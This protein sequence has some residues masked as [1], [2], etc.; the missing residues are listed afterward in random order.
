MTAAKFEAVSQDMKVMYALVCKVG[1]EVPAFK[2]DDYPP[3]IQHAIDLIPGVV[4]LS[5]SAY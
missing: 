5:L 2:F 3:V 1:K 4:L